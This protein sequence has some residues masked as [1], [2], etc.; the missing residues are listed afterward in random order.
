ML[1]LDHYIIGIVF[2][3]GIC[4]GSF[5]NVCI[6][7]IP[8]S[9]SI[10]KPPSSCPKCRNKIKFYDNIPIFSYLILMGKCRY[11][12]EKISIRY[13]LIELITGII[14]ILTYL[15]FG[16]TY[17][18]LV[19]FIFMSTLLTVSM[20]DIDHQI[21]PDVI[22]LPGIPVFF[23]AALFIPE[24]TVVDS[25]I[26]IIA[27]GGSLYLVGLTYYLIK[28]TEGMGGGDIKLLAMIGGLIGW[29]GIL[30]TVFAGSLAGS[31]IG[32]IIMA[33]TRYM[34]MKLKIPFG[35]FLSLGAILYLFFGDLL[36][37]WYFHL[38]TGG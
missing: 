1:T 8:A 10:V 25:I 31:V 34:N 4:I 5:L 20:I 17:T 11:C 13:P 33:T 24:I 12:Q 35:P 36:I 37:N 2:F 28:K 3:Y 38:L 19:Y 32:F 26:G 18:S 22:S 27:G 9:Q 7:R 21:I 30:F 6:F 14:A 15:S 23:I 29:K 16:L